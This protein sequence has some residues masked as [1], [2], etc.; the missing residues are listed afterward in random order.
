MST[1][2]DRRCANAALRAARELELPAWLESYAG[3]SAA[4]VARELV[5]TVEATGGVRAVDC[6]DGTQALSPVGAPGWHDLG[7]AYFAACVALD[8]APEIASEDEHTK[9]ALGVLRTAGW[10]REHDCGGVY[11]WRRD[12]ADGRVLLATDETCG[13]DLSCGAV[14]VGVYTSEAAIERSDY[15][16][17]TGFADLSAFAFA[18]ALGGP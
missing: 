7:C 15:L 13:P 4:D 17:G 3:A 11:R 1:E 14:F 18:V 6:D 5:A 2:D 12:R 10:Y 8:R 9:A 16:D